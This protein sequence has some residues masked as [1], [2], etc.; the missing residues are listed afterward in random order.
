M[1]V[2]LLIRLVFFLVLH[3]RLYFFSENMG[4]ISI[5][6]VL[7]FRKITQYIDNR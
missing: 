5:V 2:T 4:E 7:H 6:F 3:F 1:G